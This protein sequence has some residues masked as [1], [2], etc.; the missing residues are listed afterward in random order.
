MD[1]W[2]GVDSSPTDL[3]TGGRY[4]PTGD[5]WTATNTFD[6]PSARDYHTAVWTGTEMIIWGGEF[7]S[8]PPASLD[9]G[10][11]YDP[12]TDGWRATG[13]T[14]VPHARNDHTA[15]WIG[16]KMIVLGGSYW[17]NNNRVYLNTGGIYCAQALPTPTPTPTAT[18]SP[19]STPT[20]T[21]TPTSTAI[22]TASATPTATVTATATTTPTSTPRTEPTPKGRP[23]PPPRP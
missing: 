1:V 2:G 14:N 17:M 16:D 18:A 4:N 5:S 19:T 9:T 6:A 3:N 12:A 8:Q 10:G 11:R 13:I 7:G 23:T 21:T 22:A 15:V 20:A